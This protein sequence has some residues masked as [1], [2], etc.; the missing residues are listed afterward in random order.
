MPMTSHGLD[1]Y[2]M[3]GDLFG[4]FPHPQQSIGLPEIPGHI[5]A[6]RIYFESLAKLFQTTSPLPLPAMNVA[7]AIA[8]G[9][10]VVRLLLYR[11]LKSGQRLIALPITVIN[12]KRPAP[13]ALRPG[14]AREQ[15]RD[16]PFVSRLP[17]PASVNDSMNQCRPAWHSTSLQQGQKQNSDRVLL[18]ADT[19]QSLGQ[20]IPF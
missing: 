12:R 8:N 9:L 17:A 2:G 5:G 11:A 16:Q 13:R 14:L 4:V 15:E 19:T 6:A 3:A 20:R 10:S 7:G 1:A 18:L